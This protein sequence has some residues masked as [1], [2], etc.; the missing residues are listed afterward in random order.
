MNIYWNVICQTGK[1][2]NHAGHHQ[3]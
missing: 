1:R 2:I 3:Q